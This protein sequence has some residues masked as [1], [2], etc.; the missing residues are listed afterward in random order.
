M[1]DSLSNTYKKAADNFANACLQICDK[2]DSSGL[3]KLI[4]REFQT[5]KIESRLISSNLQ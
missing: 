5:R 4:V 3:A 2:E 1:D